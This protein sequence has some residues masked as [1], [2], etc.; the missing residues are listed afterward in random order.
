MKMKI[1]L[2]PGDG[3]GPEIV[4]SVK[5]IFT[6]ANAPIEWEE[7]NAGQTTLEEK[8]EL[9]PADLIKSLERTKVGLKGPITTPV[10]KGFKS[11][12]I[13]L[14]QQFDLYANLRPAV[15]LPGLNTKFDNVDLVLFRENTEGLYAGLEVY[16]ERLGI[17]DSIARITRSGCEKIIRSAFEYA[18][19]NNRKKITLVHKAN[20]LKISG[21]TFLNAG[22]KNLA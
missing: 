1:T 19:R 10:G 8:G 20:I 7:E 18:K 5:A 17:A 12:N 4:E 11:V 15:T 3:I 21:A 14:R 9:I 16:D 13:Q 6:A 2:I 22:E